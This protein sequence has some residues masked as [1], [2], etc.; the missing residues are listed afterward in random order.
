M[1]TDETF[2]HVAST[3]EFLAER[4]EAMFR[5]FDANNDNK[6][7]WQEVLQTLV[8]FADTTDP[9]LKLDLQFETWDINA[10]G[11]LSYEE[12]HKSM[13][14]AFQVSANMLQEQLTKRGRGMMNINVGLGNRR[15]RGPQIS[16]WTEE[17]KQSLAAACQKAFADANLG[18]EFTDAIFGHMGKKKEEKIAKEDYINFMMEKGDAI[19]QLR[20]GMSVKIMTLIEGVGAQNRSEKMNNYYSHGV[21]KFQ[22]DLTVGIMS[23][24]MPALNNQ[25]VHNGYSK[26]VPQQMQPGMPMMMPGMM[27][28]PTPMMNHPLMPPGLI[29]ARF[30]A[31][32]MRQ[33]GGG[34][35]P[36]F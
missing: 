6:I 8:T 22:K 5:I 12:I 7:T 13:T 15:N 9:R 26:G 1:V 30:Q 35:P 16:Q 24:A 20:A 28:P 31:M 11:F 23:R 3:P 21:G 27:M 2:E 14:H 19:N 17:E 29:D 4:R 33:G 36:M 18:A 25:M 34:V 10:D 32:G